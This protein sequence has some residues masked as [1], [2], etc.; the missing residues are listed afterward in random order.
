MA[1][2][3]YA[4]VSTGTCRSFASHR[5]RMLHRSRSRGAQLAGRQFRHVVSRLQVPVAAS[6]LLSNRL[7]RGGDSRASPLDPAI[8]AEG[9]LGGMCCAGEP[10]I[11]KG[12]DHHPVRRLVAGIQRVSGTLIW[13]G[14]T[15]IQIDTRAFE[16]ACCTAA[17]SGFLCA[18]FLAR[19]SEIVLRNV[20]RIE[21]DLVALPIRQA[22]KI[23]AEAPHEHSESGFLR[24]PFLPSNASGSCDRRH[25]R[26]S[27][28]RRAGSTRAQ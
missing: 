13:H 14:S 26:S 24:R 18:L 25:G 17:R 10:A 27:A 12:R 6:R 28:A 16:L 19:R 1:H 2:R 5:K 21:L 23:T 15:L 4:M 8:S 7:G 11:F 9:R 22:D 3:L 20:T